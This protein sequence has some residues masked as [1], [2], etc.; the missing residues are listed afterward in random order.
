MW[1][2]GKSKILNHWKI[3]RKTQKNN[4]LKIKRILEPKYKLGGARFLHLACQ[5]WE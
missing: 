4:L 1:V 5:G 2:D 3:L